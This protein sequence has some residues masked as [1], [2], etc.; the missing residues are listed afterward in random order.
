[1]K[2]N[3]SGKRIGFA[4]SSINFG[5][6]LKLWLKL[7]AYASQE[8]G[9]FF[10]FPGSSL[11]A[12]DSNNLRNEIYRLVNSEN[13]DGVISWASS[14]GN[15]ATA[16]QITD[17]HKKFKNLPLVTIG[18]KVLNN[19]SVTFNAYEGMKDLTKHLIEVHGVKKIAF[20]RGP[21][22]H[23]SAQD[24]FV[25]FCDATKEAGIFN[26]NLITDYTDWH[27]GEQ[28][29]Q[30]LYED[31]GLIPGKDFDAIL[32][33]SDIMAL[34]VVEYFEKR[35]YKIPKD[36]ICGGFNDSAESRICRTTF[37]TVHMPVEKL[38]IL[39]YKKLMQ[40]LDGE[41]NIQDE[42]LPAYPVIRE[43]CG[44]NSLKQ[45]QNFYDSKTRI[46]NRDE[47]A[48]ALVKL[49]RADDKTRETVFVPMLDA[50]F[51][52]NQIEFYKRLNEVFYSYFSED[53]ELSNIFVALR[54]LKNSTF[55]P[56]EYVAKVINTINLMI[57]QVQ[58][59]ICETR[60]Y[61]ERVASTVSSLKT[62]LLS[63]HD[64]KTLMEVLAKYLPQIG[65]KNA[66]IVL[67]ETDDISKYVGS[68]N[69]VG[70]IKL[71]NVL[72]SSNLLVPQKFQKEYDYGVFLVQPLFVEDQPLGYLITGYSDCDGNIYEDLR[73]SVSTT[74]QSIRLFEQIVEA[75]HLAEQAEFAKTEFFA[76]V[77]NELSDPLKDLLA[78]IVQMQGNIEKGILDQDILSEQLIFLRSQIQTQLQKTVTLIDL[79]RSQVDDLPMDKKLF[80]IRQV[81]P[82][83]VVASLDQMFPL[84]YGD[85]ERIKKAILTLFTYGD[86]C[87]MEVSA[88]P[89]GLKIK[90]NSIH[91]D[92]RD[93]EYLL[94]EKIV[95]LQYG[96]FK[97]I[98]ENQTLIV[99]PWPNLA[100][101]PPLKME[102]TPKKVLSLSS[103]TEE[104]EIFNIKIEDY[105]TEN[106]N[107]EENCLLFWRSDNAP[108]DEWVKVYSLRHNEKLFRMPILCYSHELIS[109]NFVE[110]LESKVRSQKSEPVLFINTKRTHYGT[111]ATDSNTVKIQSMA[112]F[113][114]ILNEITPSLI[115]FETI[116]EKSI[117]KIRKNQKTVLVPILVLPDS[118]LSEEDVEMLC[119]H[120]RIILCNSG[121]A[122]SEQF[123]KRIHEILAGDEILPPHTGA[124]VK[125]AILYLNKNASQ[126]IV[127][128][129]LADNVHVSED[130]LTRIF[131][132][133]IGLSLWE[134]LNR[135]R[136]YLATK[137]LLETNDTIY[138]IAEKSGFQDQAYFCRVFK[139]IYGVPPGRIRTKQ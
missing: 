13:L 38:G 79:T 113:D 119:S 136:I 37:S 22:N 111:W 110:M 127:R 30:Q 19:P 73:T 130:Y 18:Q 109:H 77:G 100:G 60:L 133:E 49:F 12:K 87:P 101:L 33:A 57:P 52:N 24:R 71:E 29:A 8:T 6:S 42:V 9:S 126:Q 81:L 124:L 35:G 15:G 74:I 3:N 40:I 120:P 67:Y 114:H 89:E 138:E 27:N 20:V 115:V 131:H 122:E 16:E 51:E 91:L 104:K 45:L 70:E 34:A 102:E 46:K 48:D 121:A 31:R 11:S 21:Q 58:G 82:G 4:L 56:E 84:V 65:I 5:S 55:L 53:G 137:M 17:F 106:T 23:T 95:L 98:G 39:A 117:K 107:I 10:I 36:Y 63:S 123:D 25:G 76:N 41:S 108:I 64:F 26:E 88:E 69:N 135:Y 68:F 62:A 14:I 59:K 2:I 61:D 90:I 72:F 112:E 93:P 75:R 50:L 94:A 54:Y 44:C 47:F 128:W 118:I 43:S 129:K 66:T 78:K 80:D 1:M 103:K 32:A 125:K 132:K 116:N 83:S 7:A 86:S 99:L 96:E 134:Y 139:K 28:A 85:P 92:R 105:S 97:K